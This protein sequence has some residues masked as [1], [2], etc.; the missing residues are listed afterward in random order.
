MAERNPYY[1]RHGWG[2]ADGDTAKRKAPHR[3][4]E[5]AEPVRS[6]NH[7]PLCGLGVRWETD[8]NG[9]L[10]PTEGRFVHL[11]ELN[12]VLENQQHAEGGAVLEYLRRALNERRNYGKTF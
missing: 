4:R 12:Q 8:G 7:C 3:G 5:A 11:C 2:E 9:R 10:V 1:G 6:V